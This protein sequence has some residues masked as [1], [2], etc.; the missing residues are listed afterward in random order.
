M[1]E[2]DERFGSIE[3]RISKAETRW[4]GLTISGPGW[5]GDS[6][7][8]FTFNP[9]LREGETSEP[10][11]PGFGACCV[12]SVCSIQTAPGCASI[13]G[14]YG[15]DGTGCSPNPCGAVACVRNSVRIIALLP[16]GSDFCGNGDEIDHPGGGAC[17]V[18]S[19]S[20]IPCT[21]IGDSTV[22]AP[23]VILFPFGGGFSPGHPST[24]RFVYTEPGTGGNGTWDLAVTYAYTV[25]CGVSID[26]STSGISDVD[27]TIRICR[28]GTGT[29]P[30]CSGDLHGFFLDVTV[31]FAN[32]QSC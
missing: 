31:S 12:G 27:K 5:A 3:E 13:G 2:L 8:G 28:P 32:G 30:A 10:I 22:A 29:P 17:I 21:A 6:A 24:M 9:P 16:N 7:Q 1:G 4:G 20:G 19:R 26:W 18:F 15:G 11:P 25:S 14:I 23:D